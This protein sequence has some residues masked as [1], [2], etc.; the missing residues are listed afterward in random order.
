MI[1]IGLGKL[2]C[3]FVFVVDVI[4]CV[5]KVGGFCKIWVII[6]YLMNVFVNS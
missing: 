2:F 1:G 5:W 3:F 6:V 4:V